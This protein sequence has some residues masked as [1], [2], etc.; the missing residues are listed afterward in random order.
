ML[1]WRSWGDTYAVT[2]LPSPSSTETD[3]DP[4]GPCAALE[5]EDG[6]DDAEGETETGADEH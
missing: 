1:G 4:G 2:L 6:E 3:T 5:Q